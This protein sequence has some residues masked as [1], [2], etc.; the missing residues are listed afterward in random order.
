MGVKVLLIELG[1]PWENGHIESFDGK[2]RGQLLH[3][4]IFTTL[5]E[6]R[7]LI[8]GWRRECN[9]VPSHSFLGYRPPAPRAREHLIQNVGVIH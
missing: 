2:L 5:R 7:S 9:K 1:S 4:E 6:G 3:R 8:D